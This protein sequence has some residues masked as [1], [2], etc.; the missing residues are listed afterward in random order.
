MRSNKSNYN[1]R[2]KESKVGFYSVK[3]QRISGNFHSNVLDNSSSKRNINSLRAKVM[4]CLAECLQ[5]TKNSKINYRYEIVLSQV[6]LLQLKSKFKVNGRF[7]GN[8]ELESFLNLRKTNTFDQDSVEIGCIS[9]RIK[10]FKT[11]SLNHPSESFTN[12]PLLIIKFIR[13][14]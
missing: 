10:N 9:F 4:F 12:S 8:S 3:N 6:N 14:R 2:E 1:L 13:I 5:Y 11:Y 7:K